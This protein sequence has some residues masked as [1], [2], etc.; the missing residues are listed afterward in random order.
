VKRDVGRD[1]EAVE[2]LLRHLAVLARVQPGDGGVG[3]ALH[4]VIE[5][6]ELDDL[7]PSAGNEK[8]VFHGRFAVGATHTSLSVQ[9]LLRSPACPP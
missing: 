1:L 2:H 7:G 3:V 5:R 8:N 6:R 9:C 4:R